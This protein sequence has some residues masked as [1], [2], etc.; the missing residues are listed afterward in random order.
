VTSGFAIGVVLSI[1]TRASLERFGAEAMI[2]AGD[3]TLSLW[4]RASGLALLGWVYYSAQ[5][6]F[7]WCGADS[8]FCHD[9]WGGIVPV[10][11]SVGR[12]L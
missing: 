7:F 5:V 10:Q 12:Q 1:H 8:D 11:R 6:F 3:G 9:A 2:P 4:H